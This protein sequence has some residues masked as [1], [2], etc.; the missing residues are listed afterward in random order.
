MSK[1]PSDH[2]FDLLLEAIQELQAEGY[3][4]EYMATET[5]FL[6]ASSGR[7]YLPESISEIKVIRVDQ[8]AAESS[9]HCILYALKMIDG[10][11]G[12]I[13]D[14]AGSYADE[15]LAEHFARTQENFSGES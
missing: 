14:A 1:K 10:Q 3:T 2:G 8:P 4:M 13:S 12:W 7:V 5:G 6:D 9:A 15:K 11:S